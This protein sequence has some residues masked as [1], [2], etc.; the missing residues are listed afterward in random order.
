GGENL[1][2]SSSGQVT[3]VVGMSMTSAAF[4]GLAAATLSSSGAAAGLEVLVASTGAITAGVST[5]S[6]VLVQSSSKSNMTAAFA[7]QNLATSGDCVG[8][9]NYLM[10]CHGSK[11]PDYFLGVGATHAG[12]GAP[13]DNG[14]LDTNLRYLAAPDTADVL[15]G[16]KMLAGSMVVY[17][18]AAPAT[19]VEI[20]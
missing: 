4:S 9:T 12:V 14:F 20:A 5:C 6:G 16:V 19:I 17:L 11:A 2:I 7:Y 10:A 13:S 15:C 8:V 18:L 3:S 1:V